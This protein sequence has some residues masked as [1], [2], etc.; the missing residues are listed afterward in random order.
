MIGAIIGDVIGSRFEQKNNKSKQFELFDNTCK[1]TDD[2]I[3]SLAIAKAI[4]ESGGNYEDLSN[5]AIKEM[6]ELGRKY[7]YAGYG[8]SF[9]NWIRSENPRPYGS[10]GNGSAMRVSPCGFAANSLEEAKALSNRVTIVTHN[11][12]EG[13]KGAEA[14]AV[15]VFLAKAGASKKAI[16]SYIAENYYPMDFKIA[17]IRHDYKYD[18]SCQGSVPVAL[19]AFYESHDFIDAIRNAVSVGGDSDTIACLTGCIAEAFYGVPEDLILQVVEYLDSCEMEILYCFEKLYPSKA[20]SKDASTVFEVLDTIVDKVFPKGTPLQSDAEF[21]GNHAHVFIDETHMIPD[22]SSFDKKKHKETDVQ[23]HGQQ[24]KSLDESLHRAIAEYNN[25]YTQLNEHGIQLFNQ[26]E[27]SVDLLCHIEH[28]INSI[29]NKPKEFD[30]VII[31]IQIDRKQFRDACEFAKKELNAA[32]E[33]AFEA[34]AGVA[35]GIAVA[36]L[37]PS[38]AMWIATTF[39]TASTGTAIS[40]LSGAAATK[41]ALAW[42]GGGALAT[43]GG[44]IAAGNAL[45]AL[46]GPIG[47]E[48]AGV[49]IL[50]SILL[51]TNKK[52]KLDNE[53]KKEIESVVTNTEKVKET[54][55]KI[56][57]LLRKTSNLRQLLNDQFH[58]GLNYFNK[59][60]LS[61]SE[62]GQ[63]FLGTLVNN[64]KA[65]AASLS[66]GV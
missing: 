24:P 15:A 23:R 63:L 18:T 58:A 50:T 33:S 13:I 54:D 19:E 4:I 49:S 60:Y 14:I 8:N 41:A 40:T 6:Q 28:L 55:A 57:L 12:P 46:A 9:I 56:D 10:Y 7:P 17:K 16:Q 52:K 45:L 37:A 32:R 64:V 11:H 61:I 27:R 38:A 39:E 48:I 59:D 35:G 1:L 31:E 29:A 3:M 30:A 42:L 22:F 5:L 2:S 21:S 36:A 62:D 34:G 51:F 20:K 44:G 53:K 25:A 26:R 66:K 47:W 65:L 43:G